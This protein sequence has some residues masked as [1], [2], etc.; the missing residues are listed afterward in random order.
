VGKGP[1]RGDYSGE[2][3]THLLFLGMERCVVIMVAIG[4]GVT[5]NY[6]SPSYRC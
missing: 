2:P 5:T 3:G 6:I 1:V 4:M